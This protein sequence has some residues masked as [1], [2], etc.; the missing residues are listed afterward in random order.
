MMTNETK[1]KEKSEGRKEWINKEI[2]KERKEWNSIEGKN[3]GST[4]WVKESKLG[5]V[6]RA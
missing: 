1:K 4:E 3:K 5:S 6:W 2:K